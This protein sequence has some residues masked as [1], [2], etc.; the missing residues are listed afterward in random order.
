MAYYEYVLM[1]AINGK[2]F[3]IEHFY[4]TKQQLNNILLVDCYH[5]KTTHDLVV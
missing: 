4:L 5:D 1:N 2:Q 3:D